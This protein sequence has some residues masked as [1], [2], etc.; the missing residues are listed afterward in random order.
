LLGRCSTTWVIRS[1]LFCFMLFFRLE[2]HG[3]LPGFFVDLGLIS[4]QDP[5]D[6]FH[7]STWNFRHEPLHLA[8]TFLFTATDWLVTGPCS[9]KRVTVALMSLADVIEGCVMACVVPHVVMWLHFL[10]SPLTCLGKFLTAQACFFSTGTLEPLQ[11]PPTTYMKFL[12][13]PQLYTHRVCLEFY[14]DLFSTYL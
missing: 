1:A 5:P 13:L 11:S 9:K 3:F 6:L 7:T 12:S 2:S 8:H 10:T 14:L 4:N